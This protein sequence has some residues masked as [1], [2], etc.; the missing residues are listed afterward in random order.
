[1]PGPSFSSPKMMMITS[2]SKMRE[3]QGMA[4]RQWG[5]PRPSWLWLPK[6]SYMY[7]AVFSVGCVW[8]HVLLRTLRLGPFLFRCNLNAQW[9]SQAE[10]KL[11]T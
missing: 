2:V 7:L 1:M 6:R 11:L 10:A 8:P 3:N 5:L 4:R 9:G